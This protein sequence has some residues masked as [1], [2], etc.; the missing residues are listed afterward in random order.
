MEP[1]RVGEAKPPL[2]RGTGSRCKI[3]EC[4]GARRMEA[5]PVKDNRIVPHLRLESGDAVHLPML[6]VEIVPGSQPD[7]RTPS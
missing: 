1:C 6:R 5:G 4:P 2:E 3:V 7:F